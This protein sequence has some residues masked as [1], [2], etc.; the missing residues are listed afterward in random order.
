MKNPRC[1]PT[2]HAIVAALISSTSLV[3][4]SGGTAHAYDVYLDGTANCVFI[5][6]AIWGGV[7]SRPTL[8]WAESNG[9][10]HIVTLRSD[11]AAGPMNRDINV[12]AEGGND[13]VEFVAANN[14]YPPAACDCGTLGFWN[15]VIYDGYYLDIHAGAG[16][17][18][19]NG[20]RDSG[21]TWC[22]GDA[23]DD[24]LYSWS[25]IG[26]LYGGAD[27]DALVVAASGSTISLYGEGGNDCLQ[28]G[29]TYSTL[30]CGS[31]LDSRYN[32]NS[33]YTSCEFVEYTC[34][35]FC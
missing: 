20:A 27:S 18:I 1:S 14:T 3:A 21:D 13:T 26:D 5:G 15:K 4:A 23:G 10:E 8:C 34:C 7:G 16:A 19:I 35:G 11:G 31:G 28:A 33:S 32:G 17:D 6:Q 29:S 25:T 24:Q 12:Y 9:T 30:D 22:Y 2:A